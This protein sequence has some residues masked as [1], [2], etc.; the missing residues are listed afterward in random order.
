MLSMGNGLRV[1]PV[2]LMVAM[3]FSLAHISTAVATGTNWTAT[4]SMNNAR[5]RH[6]AVMLANGKVLIVGGT[7]TG[8]SAPL[9]SAELYDPAAG[10]W[11]T[12]GSMANPRVYHTATLLAN[13]KVL[14]AGGYDG[15]QSL[16]SAELYDPATGTWTA[17]GS[18]TNPRPIHTATLLTNGKVL[19]AGGYG[20]AGYYLTSAEL[21]DPATGIWSVTG[22]MANPR[23]IHTA[24]LLTNGKVLVAGGDGNVGPVASA[25]LYGELDA[26]ALLAKLIAS[27][28][29]LPGI[30]NGLRTSLLNH[31]KNTQDQNGNL[32]SACAQMAAFINRVSGEGSIS[33]AQK[34][35]LI[36]DAIAVRSVLG[37]T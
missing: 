27:V 33:P 16:A 32:S 10:T 4:G 17:T 22:S 18:M 35:S 34:A 14:V 23:S 19:V 3:I 24:T 28:N 30:S 11:A 15:S 7:P 20:R 29:A 12:T 2:A 26:I 6:S 31:L 9:A 5:H 25:E 13:G 8:A 36:A 21:Y 1:T 37:C